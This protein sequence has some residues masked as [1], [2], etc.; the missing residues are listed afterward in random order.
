[1]DAQAYAEVRIPDLKHR[2]RRAAG[3][4]IAGKDIMGKAFA[5]AAALA[6][7]AGATT[8]GDHRAA[9]GLAL[10]GAASTIR[11]RTGG[12]SRLRFVE[13]SGRGEI[14]WARPWNEAAPRTGEAPAD[15]EAYRSTEAAAQ[16]STELWASILRPERAPKVGERAVARGRA[17]SAFAQLASAN[18]LSK[19]ARAG[20]GG[21]EGAKALSDGA[22]SQQ[23]ALGGEAPEILVDAVALDPR[24]IGGLGAPDPLRPSAA[25]VNATPYQEML[26]RAFALARES[27]RLRKAAP[28]KLALG[29]AI[30]AAGRALAGVPATASAGRAMLATGLAIGAKGAELLRQSRDTLSRAHGLAAD[31]QLL[32]GQKTQRSLADVCLDEVAKGASLGRCSPAGVMPELS[33]LAKRSVERELSEDASFELDG[34]A[35][36]AL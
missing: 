15:Y 21:D 9:R 20:L 7:S 23:L 4:L 3:L 12:E 26:E 22:F 32:E 33:G 35:R 18:G 30:A 36:V 24:K 16:A 25:A 8:A 27:A 31:V 17:A 2:G 6:L 13:G 34:G 5:I 29:A 28:P 1:M 10:G 11:P 14:K 19:A